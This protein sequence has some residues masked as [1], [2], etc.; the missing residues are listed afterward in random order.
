MPDHLVIPFHYDPTGSAAVLEQDTVAEVA[1]CVRVLLSTPT[2]TR[3]E[4]YDYGIGDPTFSTEANAV[5]DITA[6]VARWE[7]RAAGV[8]LSVTVQDDG[9]AQ[10]VAR[11]PDERQL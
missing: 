4:E 11:I 9:S 7:P 1:Q 6:A 2:G 8:R 5:A 3:V 10:I